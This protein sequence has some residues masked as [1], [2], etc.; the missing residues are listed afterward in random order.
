VNGVDAG[1]TT[2]P[3]NIPS[4]IFVMA[5]APDASG[6][7]AGLMDEAR[8]FTFTPG[9]FD[10]SELLLNVINLPSFENVAATATSPSGAT[11]KAT[12]H[13]G[14]V[15]AA[16]W[17]EFGQT[18]NYG[19]FTA[20]NAVPTGTVLNINQAVT[21]LT[22]GSFYHFRIVGTNSS[23][24]NT[25][26]D[27]IFFTAAVPL[28][29]TLPATNIGATNA[30][31]LGSVNPGTAATTVYFQ[32]G[33]T[34][35][36]DSV[37]GS[38]LLS[39]GSGA[40]SVSNLLTGLPIVSNFHFRVVA[41]N[42]AGTSF[43]ADLSFTTLPLAPQV[44]TLAAFAI[45]SQRAT[46]NA[47][48]NPN[49]A[50]SLA[51]FE[52]G[53]TTNYGSFSATSSIPAGASLAISNLVSGLSSNSIYHFRAAASNSVQ[54][55]YGADLTF[56]TPLLSVTNFA[57][58]RLGEADPG[59]AAGQATTS[60][61]DS[62][63]THNLT[64]AY[65][66]GPPPGATYSSD[67]ASGAAQRAGS[68][69]SL[70]VHNGYA[71]TASIL[72]SAT[73]NFALEVWAKPTGSAGTQII[74]YN[75]QPTLS[76]WGIE[77]VGD[78]VVAVFGDN[79]H[80]PAYPGGLPVTITVGSSPVVLDQWT[81]L[82]LVRNNG[83]ATFYVNGVPSGSTTTGGNVPA[84]R[85]ALSAYPNSVSVGRFSGWVDEV[86]I[87]TFAAGAFDPSDLLYAANAPALTAQFVNNITTS[88]ATLNATIDP[89]G[90]PTAALFQWGPT[91]NYG[92]TLT[93]PLG[94]TTGLQT[95]SNA[96][97]GLQ[98]GT[99]YQYGI[100]ATNS[101]GQ[102]LGTNVSFV[103]LDTPRQINSLTQPTPGQF[104]LQFAG[105]P[106]IN[107]TVM[108]T[109]NLLLPATN[110]I[111]LGSASY[112]SNGLFQFDVPATNAAPRFFM[113]RSP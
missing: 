25:S 104:R 82:A 8:C 42:N 81:H 106:D 36:Y 53:S 7:F 48:V 45:R 72:S 16:A 76:G 9:L 50:D 3:P 102:A 65:V 52:Y 18:T 47:S 2:S 60:S 4:G 38:T 111:N 78:N 15:N 31:L 30:T 61:I 73:D 70:D 33:A 20:T 110:W 29:T 51:W 54:T 113:L 67:V 19:S 97:T 57:Y 39:A 86:R 59:A 98:S 37:S 94:A 22:P 44:T 74:A 89:N 79:D 35:N 108:A 66:P 12:V 55:T 68:S 95:I 87:I 83:T 80:N 84:A 85:F 1:T 13:S 24:R 26:A 90:S 10:P 23:G 56:T 46:L 11:L 96:L 88:G 62:A 112:L 100:S 92:N 107:Y 75:G 21:G 32:Y 43:G 34:T 109:T 14:G 17:F 93:V 40:Q 91:T 28:V 49:G 101:V 64:V 71:T 5:A 58:Y 41:T 105:G 103:T 69:L 27:N 99:R 6:K 77:R 63:G